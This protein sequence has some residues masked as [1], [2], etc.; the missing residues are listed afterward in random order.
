MHIQD[1]FLARVDASGVCWEWVGNKSTDGYGRFYA[2]GKYYGAHRYAWT[3]LVGPITEGYELDHL[4]MNPACVDPDHLEPVTPEENRR[5]KQSDGSKIAAQRRTH[6]K[7]GH[8]L[9]G[10]NLK[11]VPPSIQTKC[12]T[13]RL[14]RECGKIADRAIYAKFKEQRKAK[15]REYNARKKLERNTTVV[16]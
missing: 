12:P 15:Q 2:E 16:A 10:D 14:C 8:L 3:M 13:A 1:R 9:A 7:R 5:R 6:C 11:K 4:C